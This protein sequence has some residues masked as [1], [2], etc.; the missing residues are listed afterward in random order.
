MQIEQVIIG[1]AGLGKL[2]S[3]REVLSCLQTAHETGIRH[4][5]VA[6][7]YGNGHMEAIC[8]SFLEKNPEV[9]VNTKFGLSP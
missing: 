5:D 3:P 2:A 9:K 4:L 1:T 8:G 6:Q 7:L